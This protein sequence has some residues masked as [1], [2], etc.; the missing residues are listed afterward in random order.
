M[1]LFDIFVSR[2]RLFCLN[3]EHTVISDIHGKFSQVQIN[4]DSTLRDYVKQALVTLSFIT[5]PC[6]SY[7]YTKKKNRIQI[8]H[9]ELSPVKNVHVAISIMSRNCRYLWRSI[10]TEYCI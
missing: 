4:L 3:Q 9:S 10:C 1:K 5:V 8:S 2:K 6:I 7:F